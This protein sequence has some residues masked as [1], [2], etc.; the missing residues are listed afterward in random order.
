MEEAWE[1]T[2]VS[3]CSMISVESFIL[4]LYKPMTRTITGL[5]LLTFTM[6]A[7]IDFGG[8]SHPASGPLITPDSGI[9]G[10]IYL[11]DTSGRFLRSNAGVTVTLET[12]PETTTTDDSG[13]WYFRNLGFGQW[14]VT[15]TR[16]GFG[17]G[18]AY[19]DK[20]SDFILPGGGYG[21]SPNWL[22]SVPDFEMGEAPTASVL[23]DSVILT[24]FNHNSWYDSTVITYSHFVNNWFEPTD[25]IVVYVSDDS[26]FS[27]STK[28]LYLA[29]SQI[30]ACSLAAAGMPPGTKVFAA[31]YAYPASTPY[32]ELFNGGIP[33]GSWDTTYS[34]YDYTARGPQSNII[35]FTVPK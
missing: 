13:Y 7:I 27:N 17:M 2:V 20:G 28:H 22:R 1:Y 11:V 25:G 26:T 8:C 29:A 3:S 35:S 6:I 34:R 31:A 21:G 30:C 12:P 24:G 16:P 23:L 15:F 33:S 9:G 32:P 5:L 14:Y 10:R 19:V 4:F 18:W